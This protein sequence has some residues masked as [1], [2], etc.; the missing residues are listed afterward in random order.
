M[1]SIVGYVLKKQSVEYKSLVDK[2]RHKKSFNPVNLEQH[3]TLRTDDQNELCRYKTRTQSSGAPPPVG[4]LH[5]I[6]PDPFSWRRH[7][8]RRGSSG[9]LAYL[10]PHVLT[11]H[12][13]AHVPFDKTLP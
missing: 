10:C 12:L 4:R 5:R 7:A 13:Q 3:F 6:P 1:F 8:A 9:I 2:A 11:S